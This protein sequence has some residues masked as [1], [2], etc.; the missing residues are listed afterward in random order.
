M[1]SAYANDSE[2]YR[3]RIQAMYPPSR[4]TEHN[5]AEHDLKNPDDQ[6][7]HGRGDDRLPA[8]LY[9]FHGKSLSDILVLSRPICTLINLECLN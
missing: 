1:G 6:H 7:P 4:Y 3:V 8:F 5:Q 9:C 2:T